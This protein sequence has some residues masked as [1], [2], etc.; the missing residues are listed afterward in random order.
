MTHQEFFEKQRKQAEKQQRLILLYNN[1]RR[2]HGDVS[3][4]SKKVSDAYDVEAKKIR[5]SA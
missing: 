3:D 4:W 1:Y 5:E 2:E